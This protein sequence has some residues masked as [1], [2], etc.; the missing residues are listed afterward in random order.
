[1]ARTVSIGSQR[2]ADIR[3]RGCFLVDKTD[4]IRQWWT[5]YKDVTVLCRPRRFGKTLTLSMVECFFS[6]QYAGR[7]DLFEGLSIADDPDLALT[8]GAR[9]AARVT[10]IPEVPTRGMAQ[11]V[12]LIS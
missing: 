1:M 3:E 11:F 10:F 12:Q 4:F 8:R 2:F 5:S 9:T 7:A 6:T